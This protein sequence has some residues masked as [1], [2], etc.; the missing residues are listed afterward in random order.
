MLKYPIVRPVFYYKLYPITAIPQMK[1]YIFLIFC[2]LQ[3]HIP[4][5]AND[6]L[7]VKLSI[8]VINSDEV[9]LKLY[10]AEYVKEYNFSDDNGCFVLNEKLNPG[11]YHV[12]TGDRGFYLYLNHGYDLNLEITPEYP[13]NDYRISGKGSIENDQ[14]LSVFKRSGKQFSSHPNVYGGPE[15]EFVDFVGRLWLQEL[16]SLDSSKSADNRFRSLLEKLIRVR[17]ALDLSMYRVI[18]SQISKS[19]EIYKCSE[20]FP[21]VGTIVNLNDTDL[22]LVPDYIEL[23]KCFYGGDDYIYIPGKERKPYEITLINQMDSISLSPLIKEVFVMNLFEDAYKASDDNDS[24][25]SQIMKHLTDSANIRQVDRIH[26]Q[27]HAVKRGQ[28]SANFSC[29]DTAGRQYKLEDFENKILYIKIW[30]SW[31][32]ACIVEEPDFTKLAHEFDGKDIE[33]ISI[34]VDKDSLSWRKMIDEKKTP[35]LQL[36]YNRAD[37]EFLKAYM[38]NTI[39]RYIL[40]DRSGKI[41]DATALR[42]TNTKIRELLNSL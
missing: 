33:F 12:E 24:L 40:I 39:P 3:L 20:N 30:A 28:P 25:H 35:G 21:D 10:D 14:L 26:H 37:G 23:L 27:W 5:K 32:G 15:K 9:K 38:V 2:V 1:K 7:N 16:N 36:I 13:F 17:Y 11:F 34:S 6:S 22:L 4:V 42:P 29:R 41:I 8:K 19:G 18:Q 31:C